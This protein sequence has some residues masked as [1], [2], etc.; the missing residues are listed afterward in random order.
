MNNSLPLLSKLILEMPEDQRFLLIAQVKMIT[1]EKDNDRRK[2][3]YFPKKHLT[4]LSV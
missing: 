1:S 3:F 2:N 4:F